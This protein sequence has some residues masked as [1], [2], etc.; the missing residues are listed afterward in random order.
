MRGP[1]ALSVA[2]LAL[3]ALAWVALSGA[4]QG[5]AKD[6]EGPGSTEVEIPRAGDYRLWLYTRTYLDGTFRE[7]PEQLP[8]GTRV[9]ARTPDGDEAI[10]LQSSRATLTYTSGQTE[11]VSLGQFHFP[12][13]GTYTILAEGMEDARAFTLREA[14]FLEHARRAALFGIPGVVMFLA[15]VVRGIVLATSGRRDEEPGS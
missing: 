8:D 1:V 11:R 7:F 5:L 14:R 15:G 4:F 13:P 2:G 9:V 10:R 6:F 12:E 3:L